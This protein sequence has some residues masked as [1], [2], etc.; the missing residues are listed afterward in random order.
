LPKTFSGATVDLA[1]L[2]AEAAEY[3]YSKSQPRRWATFLKDQERY[4][5]AI[6][7]CRSA[8]ATADKKERPG[9]FAVWAIALDASGGLHREA[10]ALYEEA[11]RLQPDFWVARTNV[12][13]SLMQLLTLA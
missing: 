6:A 11:I 3:V 12:Q 8:L 2:T 13:N 1:K 5:E 7:F 4:P 9:L 10:L